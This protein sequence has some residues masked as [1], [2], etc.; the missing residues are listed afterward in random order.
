[1]SNRR[2]AGGRSDVQGKAAYAGSLPCAIDIEHQPIISLPIPQSPRLLLLLQRSGQQVFQ[3]K[4]AE[5]LDCGLVER[6]EK[7]GKRRAMRQ[8]VP[9]KQGHERVG[10]RLQALIERF[11]G[12]FA[13]DRIAQQHGHKV[14][15]IIVSEAAARKAHAL[16]NER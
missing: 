3:K 12:A 6:C 11:E 16:L 9:I 13:T 1:L 5:S 14:D 10:E 8:S 4:R 15:E 7:A 2:W